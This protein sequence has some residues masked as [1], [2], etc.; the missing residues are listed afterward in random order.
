MRGAGY[1]NAIE[2]L[3]LW[4]TPNMWHDK[5]LFKE[6]KQ[7]LN[8]LS[9]SSLQLTERELQLAYELSRGLLEAILSAIDKADDFE[10]DALMNNLTDISSFHTFLLDKPSYIN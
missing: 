7:L 4:A 9:D 3:N 2:L 10:H 1:S 8:K 6:I 5:T